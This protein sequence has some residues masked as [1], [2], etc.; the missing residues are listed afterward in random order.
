MTAK[1]KKKSPV[2]K[3]FLLRISEDTMKEMRE[4]STQEMR[5][6]NAHIE[7]ILKSALVKRSGAD[8]NEGKQDDAEDDE[9]QEARLSA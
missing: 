9:K 6:L 2:R 5:S 3:A 7:F 1:K 4:W 8:A